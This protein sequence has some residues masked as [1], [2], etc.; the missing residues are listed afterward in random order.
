MLSIDN[1]TVSFGGYELLSGISFL[2]NP[3]D[4]IGLV[5]KNGAG[6]STML[7]IICGQQAPTSG[8]V[9][10]AMPTAQSGDLPQQMRWQDTTTLA[11]MK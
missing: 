11:R 5:G 1:I 10:A 7:K 3:K 4:R 9:N 2:I 8:A 6:K